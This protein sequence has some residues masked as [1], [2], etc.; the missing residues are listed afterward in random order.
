MLLCSNAP[1]SVFVIS[2]EGIGIDIGL[3][4]LSWFPTLV[5]IEFQLM[6]P[7]GC[8]PWCMS[9]SVFKTIVWI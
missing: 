5:L 3:F 2:T 6:W 1:V 4:V 8:R 7:E 9:C